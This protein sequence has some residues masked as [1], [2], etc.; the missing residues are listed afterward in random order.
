MSSLKIIG[1]ARVKALI[2]ML[3]TQRDAEIAAVRAAQPKA[4]EAQLLA[5]K[6]VGAE[7]EFA[8]AKDVIGELI[9]LSEALAVKTG[10]RYKVSMSVDSY[11]SHSYI[12]YNASLARHKHGGID[13]TIAKIKAEYAA[14]E[15][16]LWLCETL[17]EAKA[18]V[19]V[20]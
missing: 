15:Q 3:N 2:V 14:K 10:L 7:R 12:K 17:E 16:R 20:E 6:E 8:A 11:Q 4:D 18:I 19:G 1:A 13:A 9:M 5:M